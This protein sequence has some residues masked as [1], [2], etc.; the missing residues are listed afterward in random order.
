MKNPLS[1]FGL[2][3]AKIR[4]SDKDSP[5]VKSRDFFHAEKERTSCK[6]EQIHK[7]TSICTQNG[8]RL[9]F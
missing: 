1:Y 3:D 7:L 4:A 9:S 2:V 5:A 8:P 6:A